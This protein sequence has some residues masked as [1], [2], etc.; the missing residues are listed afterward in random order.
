MVGHQPLE[1][2]AARRHELEGHVEVVDAVQ[3]NPWHVYVPRAEAR[4]TLE[5]LP[6]VLGHVAVGDL[7]EFSDAVG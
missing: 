1:G 6:E 2:K 4:F 5:A 3:A 7:L